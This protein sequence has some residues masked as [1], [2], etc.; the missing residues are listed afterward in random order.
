[1]KHPPPQCHYL[2]FDR[3]E[4][5]LGCVT[6]EA[7]AEVQPDRVAEL[8]AEWEAVLAWVRRTCPGQEGLLDEGGGWDHAVHHSCGPDGWQTWVF[9]LTAE[10][11]LVDGLEPLLG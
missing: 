6:W 11:A 4:D 9:A 2:L 5:G 7:M 10:P 8:C 1:V 3:S